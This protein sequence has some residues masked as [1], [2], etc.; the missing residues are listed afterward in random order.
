M[1]TENKMPVKGQPFAHQQKAFDFTLERFGFGADK[2][3]K[4]TGVALLMEMGCGKTLVGIAVSGF[5]YRSQMSHIG[6]VL[7]VCPL[8]ITDVWKTEY[9]IFADFP[10]N[11][12]VLSGS[13]EKKK[14]QI[15]D[16][17]VSSNPALQ[18]LVVNYESAWR[19]EKNF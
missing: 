14:Q 10:Y 4:S 15:I 17:C 8:S 2:T 16:T 13:S 5:L 3:R 12:T 11:L 18:I 1:Q 7:I 19:L 9:A 6:R